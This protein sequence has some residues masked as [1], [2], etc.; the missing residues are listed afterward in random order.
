MKVGLRTPNVKGSIKARTT[1]KVKRKFKR[2]TNPFYGKK[3]MGWL[4]NPRK[5]M[6]NKIYHKTTFSVKSLG[7][8]IFACFYYPIYWTMLLL[9]WSMWLSL[10]I[11]W[12]MLKGIV[13]L[14]I[15]AVNGCIALVEWLVNRHAENEALPEASE[16][17]DTPA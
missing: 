6:Y 1:G 4:K 14:G 10:V 12:W 11:L 13:Y 7:G 5:A 2:M 3:G 8:L 16:T 9:M 15:W 17:E